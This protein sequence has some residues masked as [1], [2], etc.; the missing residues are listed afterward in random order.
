MP[1]KS[2][3]DRYWVVFLLLEWE[4]IGN[5]GEEARKIL[6]LETPISMHFYSIHM[7][8]VIY[9]NICRHRYYTNDHT[10]CI[11]ISTN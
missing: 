5:Q 3:N 4:V 7:Q 6:Q 8:I 1:F 10:K 9:K 2:I 11:S